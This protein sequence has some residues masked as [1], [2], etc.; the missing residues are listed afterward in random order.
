MLA[1]VLKNVKTV[2]VPIYE[3]YWVKNTR[4][5]TE[6]Y[7]WAADR[8][9]SKSG[10][11]N[12]TNSS[13]EQT[14]ENVDDSTNVLDLNSP[15]AIIRAQLYEKK[16]FAKSLTLATFVEDEFEKGGRLS[17]GVK[18]R[19]E[20]VFGYYRPLVCQAFWLKPDLLLILRKKNISIAIRA[21]MK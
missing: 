11:I 14:G 3:S 10:F 17:E 4:R 12:S 16:Y 13:E 6:T 20:K 1:R 19:N 18:Q 5:G 15:E 2:R 21:R 8:S 7:I 9:G